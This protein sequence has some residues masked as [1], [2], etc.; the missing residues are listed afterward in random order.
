MSNVS[1]NAASLCRAGH[2]RFSTCD[3]W[4]ATSRGFADCG[5]AEIAASTQTASE[6]GRTHLL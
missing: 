2:R 1:K 5:T 3:S 6:N 4:Q